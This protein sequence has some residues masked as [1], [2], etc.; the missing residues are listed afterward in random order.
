MAHPADD[1]SPQTDLSR[2]SDPHGATPFGVLVTRPSSSPATAGDGEG[3]ARV[4]VV[5]DNLTRAEAAD[6]ATKVS[7]VSYEVTLDLTTGPET[8]LSDTTINFA[9]N[10][11]GLASFIDIE[12]TTVRE[13]TLNGRNIDPS[14]YDAVRHRIPLRGLIA[15]NT[16][17]VVAD[18][19]Y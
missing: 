13:V 9:A 6:R 10:L 12:A 8:F 15:N 4:A 17:R 3:A 16:L 2:H 14:A 19:S 11:V 1:K 18:C 5:G 7:G